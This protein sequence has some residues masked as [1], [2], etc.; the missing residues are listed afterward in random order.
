MLDA[1][2]VFD[3]IY[4]M[5][6]GGPANS[7]ETLSIYAYRTYFQS[8]QFGYGSSVAL[9]QVILMTAL[10]WLLVQAF[11]APWRKP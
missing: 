7:T 2:R 10:A 5:T 11:H 9:I 3:V 6:G 1:F 4:V 8:L